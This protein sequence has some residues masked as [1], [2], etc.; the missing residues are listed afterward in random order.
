MNAGRTLT[1]DPIEKAIAYARAE[2]TQDG[3]AAASWYFDGNTT[4]ETHARV[5]KG[6]EDG[7]PAVLDTLPSPD[8]SGE[9]ADVRSGP[10]LVAEAA[11]EA[12][13]EAYSEIVQDAF[14]E[15]CDAYE[16]AFSEAAQDEIERLARLQTAD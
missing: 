15:I 2:G 16:T 13:L 7:D 5:L 12:G 9:W 11:E 3:L 6:L 1:A 4:T 8:L 14:S 10:Q